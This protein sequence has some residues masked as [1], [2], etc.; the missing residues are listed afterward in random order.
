MTNR[1]PAFGLRISALFRHWVLRHSSFLS[2]LSH[3]RGGRAMRARI[4]VGPVFVYEWLTAARRWQMYGLRALF[5]GVLF[6]AVVVV[7]FNRTDPVYSV[8]RLDRNAHA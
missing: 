1:F 3:C 5:V 7:W 2:S 6:L 4:G 8:G